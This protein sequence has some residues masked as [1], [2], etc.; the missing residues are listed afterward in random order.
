MNIWISFPYNAFSD[1][2]HAF[3]FILKYTNFNIF[4]ILTSSSRGF[5]EF[6]EEEIVSYIYK[7]NKDSFILVNEY[8]TDL[9]FKN[10]IK[11]RRNSNLQANIFCFLIEHPSKINFESLIKDSAKIKFTKCILF[12]S[13]KSRWQNEV[14]IENY[15]SFSRSYEH[16][17]RKWDDK[18][19]PI[20]GEII[21]ISK[22]PGHL[23]ETYG[24]ILMAAPEIWFGPGSWQF[25][26]PKD[27]LS[28]PNAIEI[29]E[30]IPE[31]IYVKLFDWKI[32]DYET[33]EILAL[34]KQFRQWTKMDSTENLLDMAVQKS[35][36]V[37]SIKIDFK[38]KDL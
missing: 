18:L 8:S 23:K 34:Q 11:Y 9:D 1:T 35:E 12:D 20:L 28:F 38:K 16:L 25:F 21:D 2:V 15:K 5:I 13:L 17:P 33:P 37:V 14:D 27:I 6:N 26:D 22:N 31:V 3:K 7:E 10:S 30:I 24:T 32:P 4:G 29:K 36:N 19:S